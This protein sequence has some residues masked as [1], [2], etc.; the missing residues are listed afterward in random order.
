M[1]KYVAL[2]RG[3]NVGGNNILP[4]KDLKVLLQK[5]GF[6][7]VTTYIQ[8]GNVVFDSEKKCD[9]KT[10]KKI[11]QLVENKFGFLPAV[12]LLD[13]AKL[14]GA[15][16]N[17]PFDP[18]EGKML[19]FYFLE[20]SPSVDNAKLEELKAKSERYSVTDEVFYLHA[21]DGIG[22]SKLAAKVEQCMGVN[23]T[24]RNWN[25]VNKLVTMV[26]Q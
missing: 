16:A 21:P 22:R 13:E 15:V 26:E 17:N 18:D 5:M 23:V 8:S 11:S 6:E 9:R 25:T 3:I 7:N 14:K 2:F 24:A 4:M 19:H 10:A 1:N 12:L 20:S